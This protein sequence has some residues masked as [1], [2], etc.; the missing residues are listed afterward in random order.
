[1]GPLTFYGIVFAS[2]HIYHTVVANRTEIPQCQIFRLFKF[3]GFI[4]FSSSLARWFLL[5]LLSFAADRQSVM[6]QKVYFAPSTAQLRTAKESHFPP[7]WPHIHTLLLQ[8]WPAPSGDNYRRLRWRHVVIEKGKQKILLRLW[9][10]FRP[11]SFPLLRWSQRHSDVYDATFTNLPSGT[12]APY[13]L[14]GNKGL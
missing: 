3:L 6:S 12:S 10:Y 13:N 4:L 8:F 7:G 9:A 1:M 5:L 14:R 11:L 2:W